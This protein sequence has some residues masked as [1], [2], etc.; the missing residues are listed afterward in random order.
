MIPGAMSLFPTVI[1]NST[2]TPWFLRRMLFKLSKP[3]RPPLLI[4]IVLATL[5]RAYIKSWIFF[6]SPLLLLTVTVMLMEWLILLLMRLFLI[7]WMLCGWSILL[8]SFVINFWG[9]FVIP[10]PCSVKV[11][12]LLILGI[13]TKT[14][15]CCLQ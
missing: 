4:C 15:W 13:N 14:P 8:A 7:V 3:Y 12:F 1:K 5:L 9:N 2:K 6:F 11:I 10:R